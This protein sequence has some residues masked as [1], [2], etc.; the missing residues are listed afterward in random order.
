MR[1]GTVHSNFYKVGILQPKIF[2]VLPS[3]HPCP[4]L[5]QNSSKCQLVPL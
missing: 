1:E 5:V 4:I 2:V 3:M